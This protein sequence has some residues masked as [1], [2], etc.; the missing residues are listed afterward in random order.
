MPLRLLLTL[1][2]SAALQSALTAD[3]S[4]HG[5]IPPNAKPWAEVSS[6]GVAAF[7]DGRSLWLKLDADTIKSRKAVLP[8]LCAPIRS[9][10]WKGQPAADLKIR[11][12]QQEWTISWKLD[13]EGS[14]VIEV[15]FDSVPLLPADCPVATPA[16]DGSVLL[17]AWQAKTFG[18]KILFEPQWYKNTVGYWAIESDYATWDLMIDQ[19]GTYSV[20]MLQGCGKDLGGS[21]AVVSL[22]QKDQVKAELPFKTIDTG[23][24]QNFRW[25]HLGMIEVSRAGTYSL[26]IDAT[27]IANVALFDVRSIH[28][29]R[30]ASG[31]SE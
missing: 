28:L 26:R 16:G 21:D 15:I 17:H 9:I 3:D 29:V 18:E 1:A 31:A 22:R 19:P 7:I 6:D 30:Q 4:A 13:P 14:S 10:A 5:D 25:N 8:R 11:P 12:A 20:A 24:F 27:R 23:H 2:V